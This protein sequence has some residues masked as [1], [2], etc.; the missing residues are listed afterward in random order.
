MHPAVLRGSE[1]S[2]MRIKVPSTITLSFPTLSPLFTVEK[3]KIN[4]W[5]DHVFKTPQTF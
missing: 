2:R 1:K 5:T 3:K 4:T